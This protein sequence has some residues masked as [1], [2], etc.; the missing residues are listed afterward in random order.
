LRARTR[1]KSKPLRVFYGLVFLIASILAILY[2]LNLPL[3]EIHEV[4][5]NGAKILSADE[6]KALTGIPL[7][8][9]LFFANFSQ[10]KN[11]LKNIGAIKNFKIRRLPPATVVI[12][13]H[14]R[15][16]MAAVIFSEKSIIID[17]D[18]YI[19]NQN[20][21]LT[22][23]IPNM[24][25][26]PIIAGVDEKELLKNNQIDQK[27]VE[28][29]TGIIHRLSR[30]TELKKLQVNL[31]GLENINLLLD[32]IL[33]VKLGD[34]EELEAKMETFEKLMAS[35]S[36]KWSQIEYIDVRYPDEPVIKFKK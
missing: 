27:T 32:D 36:G 6:I 5:V 9:N 22:L 29:I 33:K 28:I 7:N 24:I 21:N 23:N 18:G 3:W 13:I 19:I 25:D 4:I 11:N 14:E 10:A 8:E 2:L 16:P 26:L 34:V 35:V 17:N 12:D 1:R 15:Q 20:P 30:F 31:G